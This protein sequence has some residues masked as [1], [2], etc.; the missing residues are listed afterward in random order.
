MFTG[1][2]EMAGIDLVRDSSGDQGAER[3]SH[4]RLLR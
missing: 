1:V 2:G 3:C 4:D